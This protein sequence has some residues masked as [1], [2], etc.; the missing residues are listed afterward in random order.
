MECEGSEVTT[1]GSS[2]TYS[3]TPQ[4]SYVNGSRGIRHIGGYGGI[5]SFIDIMGAQT[6]TVHVSSTEN[7]SSSIDSKSEEKED[8]VTEVTVNISCLCGDDQMTLSLVIQCDQCGYWYHTDCVN[9]SEDNIAEL[10]R[11]DLDWMCPLCIKEADRKPANSSS[12]LKSMIDGNLTKDV[13]Y[14]NSEMK[15]PKVESINSDLVPAV[16]CDVDHVNKTLLSMTA[17]LEEHH[18]ANVDTSGVASFLFTKPVVPA[19][20]RNKKHL[21]ELDEVQLKPG[22]SWR[23]SLRQIRNDTSASII[24]ITEVHSPACIRIQDGGIANHVEKDISS[25]PNDGSYISNPDDSL[26]FPT[27]R[28][29]SLRRLG[30]VSRTSFTIVPN[31]TSSLHANLHPYDSL[32]CSVLSETLVQPPSELT[33]LQKLLGMCTN[34]EITSFDEMYSQD[35]ISS[36]TKVGE[37]AFGEVF[38]LGSDGEKRPVLKVVPIDGD[39]L[40]NG[41]VQTSI[42]DMLSEVIISKT[43]SL[44][45]QSGS[46]RTSGFVEVRGIRVFQG[47][48]PEDLLL[49][50]DKFD[51]EHES[52]NDRPD[53]L[54]HDQKFIA[55]EFNNG[56]K[57]LEK[58]TFKNASQALQAWKQVV[59]SLAVAEEEHQFEH[60]DLHWGNVLIRETNKKFVE[61][62]VNGDI[63]QVGPLSVSLV[64]M[65]RNYR[66]R[67]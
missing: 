35:L 3:P 19:P 41:E 12:V 53:N 38:L 51:I 29:P 9:L 8:I 40:V 26:I 11:E 4:K 23:R 15:T 58:F 21:E 13:R 5:T 30:N 52:E 31:D 55:L 27:P 37:G 16:P 46:N 24:N 57:D 63:Y 6:H 39:I 66:L 42:E 36:S 10:E 50:W 61:Y 67:H 45:R 65:L 47:P 64:S 44:L 56:G 34:N 49:L 25:I 22:K 59:H 2:I 62:T 33:A 60:R 14:G 17:Q 20:R 1:P 32:P 54:P 18:L 48:Y 7:L 43:L 28:K